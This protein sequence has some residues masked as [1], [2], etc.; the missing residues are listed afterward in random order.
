MGCMALFLACFLL[1]NHKTGRD[2][3]EQPVQIFSFDFEETEALRSQGIML[4]CLQ[5]THY[6]S[7]A[8]FP[9]KLKKMKQ[10]GFR[11]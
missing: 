4:L 9:N 8:D 6:T 5:F 7:L 2:P 10:E 11:V 1:Q 3:G